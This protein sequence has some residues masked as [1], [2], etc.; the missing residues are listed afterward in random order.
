MLN[1]LNHQPYGSETSQGEGLA[2]PERSGG[3]ASASRTNHSTTQIM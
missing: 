3:E 2:D 1:T